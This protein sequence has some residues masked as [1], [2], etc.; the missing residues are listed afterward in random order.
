MVEVV[1]NTYVVR[2]IERCE[3]AVLE[4]QAGDDR[5]KGS[6]KIY[7]IVALIGGKALK[8]AAF[9]R[10]TSGPIFVSSSYFVLQ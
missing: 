7:V 10:A 3:D 6:S 9:R 2:E 4:E 1:V 8:V 5:L